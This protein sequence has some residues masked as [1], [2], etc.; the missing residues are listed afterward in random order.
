MSQIMFFN[1]FF[2]IIKVNGVQQ[3]TYFKTYLLFQNIKY[4]NITDIYYML[5]TAYIITDPDR[6]KFGQ[7][8]LVRF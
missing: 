1:Y 7:T 4:N 2:H 8:N 3:T 5:Y 6:L